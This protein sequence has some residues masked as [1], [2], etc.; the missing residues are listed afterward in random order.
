LYVTSSLS[1]QYQ[2]INQT[3]NITVKNICLF[4]VLRSDFRQQPKNISAAIGDS[5]SFPCRPPRG[6]PEPKVIWKKDA[7]MIIPGASKTR[8]IVTDNGALNI[9]QVRKQDAG[10]FT[11]IATNKAG[12][13]ESSPAILRVI[14]KFYHRYLYIF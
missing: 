1:A 13:K 9:S 3:L 10:I 8:Y 7:E 6:E 2:T 14:G 4:T 5:V 11:C 12:E